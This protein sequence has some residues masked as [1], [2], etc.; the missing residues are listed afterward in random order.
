MGQ[1]NST[2]QPPEDF[3]RDDEP[4]HNKGD[5]FNLEANPEIKIVV[6]YEQPQGT[7]LHLSLTLDPSKPTSSLKAD[8]TN[9][10]RVPVEHVILIHKQ[11]KLIDELS[12]RDQAVEPDDIIVL[13]DQRLNYTFP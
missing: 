13:R 6:I 10:T 9:Y 11:N 5:N 8:L 1:S 3:E 4:T 12:L 7:G 2:S